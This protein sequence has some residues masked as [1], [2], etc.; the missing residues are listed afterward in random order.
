MKRLLALFLTVL[1]LGAL[2][3]PVCADIIVEP[4]TPIDKMGELGG[5]LLIILVLVVLPLAAIVGAV[6]LLSWL[7]RKLVRAI[8]NRK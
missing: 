8:R 3:V 4:T 5:P 6:Y 1:L 7:I 2:A